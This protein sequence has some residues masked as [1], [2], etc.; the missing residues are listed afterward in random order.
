MPRVH[1]F[2][3]L[4]VIAFL[5]SDAQ[6]GTPK[7]VQTHPPAIVST[8]GLQRLANAP[9]DNLQQ[10]LEQLL[11]ERVVGTP[12]HETVKNYI[13]DQM[14]ALGWTV[15]LDEFDDTAPIVGKQRFTNIIASVNPD[16]ERNLVL[17]CH[18]DSKYFP[19]Q[20]FIGA[21]DSAVPCAMLLSIAASLSPLLETMKDK[22]DLNLQF[23][24]FDGEEAFQSWS[25]TDSIYGARHLAERWEKEDRLKRMDVLVLLDL[26][27]TPEPNFYSYFAETENWYV[28]LLS[29][30]RRLDELGHLENYS[31]SSVSPTQRTIAYFKPHSYTAHIEDDH[32]PFLQRGVPVLHIIPSPFPDVWH[33]LEDNGDIVDL[34]TVHNLIRIFRVFIAEYI[35]LPL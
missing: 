20:K 34:P 33:K 31:T 12:G 6:T 32:I 29:A 30:E 15:D 17:A 25:A 2:L 8:S 24:F 13:I 5:H 4:I 10:A 19:G 22:K 7:K 9:M 1:T 16:A 23:I 11:V 27:G 14:K 28:Q 21:T 35:H 3:F 26:L 18:Y